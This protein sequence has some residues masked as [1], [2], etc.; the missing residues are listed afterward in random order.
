MHDHCAETR[1]AMKQKII[2]TLVLILIA[3]GLTAALLLQRNSEKTKSNDSYVNGNTAGNLY[4][5][6]LFCENGGVIFFANPSDSYKLYSRK[7]DG[8]DLKKLSND[9]ATYIN[10]DSNYVYY[11]CNNPRANTGAFSFLSID[12]DMLMCIDRKGDGRNSKVLD[13][14]PCLYATLVGNYIY[15]LRYDKEDATSLYRVKI[16]G[17]EQEK[18]DNTPYYTCGVNGQ[19]IYY[20]GIEG[21]HDIWRLNTVSNSR[22]NLYSDNCWSPIATENGNVIYYLDCNNNYK[23]AKINLATGEKQIL[24]DDRIDRYN[25]AGGYIY[26]QRSG[27]SP[28]LCRINTNGQDYKEISLGVYTDLNITG[29]YIYYRDFQSDVIFRTQLAAPGGREPFHPGTA[30]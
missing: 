5:S 21:D 2:I 28:A 9:T 30:E 29:Q 23:L 17:T 24:C 10:A 27:K 19:Y 22:E 4:N 13:R 20:N 18:I 6:G 3:G 15:Y 8:S 7:T 25:I 12:N 14:A 1:Q 26:F 16:D 11:V